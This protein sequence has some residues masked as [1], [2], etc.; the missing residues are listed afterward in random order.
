VFWAILPLVLAASLLTLPALRSAESGSPTPLGGDDVDPKR[1]KRAVVLAVGAGLVMAAPQAPMVL[2]V[3]L[4]AAGLP[5]AVRAFL[6]LVP[7]G[8]VRVAPGL[9][10]AIAVRGLLTFAFFGTDAFIPLALTDG[11]GQD[12]WVAGLALTTGTITWTMASWVQQHRIH[13]DGPRRIVGIGLA[14]TTVGV[15]LMQLLVHGAP[16]PICI[17]AWGISGFGI[18]L[19]YSS[20]SVTVLGLAKPGAEGQATSS[21]QLCDVLGVTLGTGATGAVVELGEVRDWF[22]GSSLSVAFAVTAAIGALGFVAA[23]RLPE[24]LS[25]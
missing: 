25:G 12:T 19:A 9:P 24:D 18:G 14:C 21:L 6:R 23:R 11:R 1:T 20:L 7:K 8:T 10:A 2:A 13:R 3:V 16:I 4:V 15:G 22:V 17:L 5:L